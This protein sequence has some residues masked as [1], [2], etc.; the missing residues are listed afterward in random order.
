MYIKELNI[1]NFRS[2]KNISFKLNKGLNII[3]GENN[4]GKSAI[5]DA[6]RICLGYGSFNNDISIHREF[7]FHLDRNDP[8]A[9]IQP[10]RIGLKFE[11]ESADD[12][13]LFN[14]LM[15]QD[16]DD[17]GNVE[18]RMDFQYT[19]V[20]NGSG[21]HTIHRQIWGGGNEGNIIDLNEMQQVFYTYLEPLRNA[22]YE[23]RPYAKRNKITS[24]FQELTKYKMKDAEGNEIEQSLDEN[25][26]DELAGKLEE[27]V[28]GEDWSGLLKSGQAFVNEHLEKADV[29]NKNAKIHI[30]LLEYKYNNIV[31]GILT[32][33]HVYSDAVL[34]GNPNKQKY[35]DISQNGLGEN[36]LIY[37]SAVLGD[38]ENRRAEGKEHYYAMLIEEPEAHLHPHRQNTFFNHLNSLMEFGVQL[39]VTSHSPT[40]TAKT[41]LNALHVLS[42]RNNVIESFDLS[43]SILSASNKSHLRKFLDV[44]KSQLFFAHGVL[45]V[46]GIS[47]TLL[48]PA[49]AKHYNAEWDLDKNGIEVVNISGVSFEPFAKLFNSDQSEERL[50]SKCSILTDD[51]R[52]LVSSNDFLNA[53]IGIESDLA[54]VIYRAVRVILDDSNR[55]EI[56]YDVELIDLEISEEHRDFV[57]EKLDKKANT[58]SARA[59]KAST[60]SGGNLNIELAEITF[61]YELLVAG[62]NI[63][64]IQGI[65]QTMHPRTDFLSSEHP[66]EERAREFLAKLESFKDKSELSQQIVLNLESEQD[67]IDGFVVPTYIVSALTHIL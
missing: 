12:R 23:L 20:P 13:R 35:F 28:N 49:L 41:D 24:L 34:A 3:I 31:K 42:N 48:I 6:L 9:E 14:S 62:D 17:I 47:E 21:N 44:T 56:D 57:I 38:I 30:G 36:N 1:S 5:I 8:D 2:I 53:E 10:I 46:E 40:I 58:P 37:S 64:L 32:K 18:L 4:S 22:E 54:K 29:S 19:L 52:G 27:V 11:V 55:L 7:D 25:H 61:E 65:Y 63:D 66:K 45:L 50:G 39:F 59:Q 16:P 67:W 15:W 33:K 60:L 51:D 43:N 26:K